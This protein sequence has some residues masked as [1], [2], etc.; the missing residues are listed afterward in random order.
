MMLTIQ[1]KQNTFNNLI[2]R[3]VGLEMD[4]NGTLVD[5]DSLTIFSFKGKAI[6]IMNIN[7]GDI[8]YDPYNNNK[9]MR[10]IFEFFTHK[11]KEETGVD[12]SAFYLTNTAMNTPGQGM[13][14]TDEGH[15]ESALYKLDC[16]K[17]AELILRL[18]GTPNAFLGDLDAE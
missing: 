16:L 1:Q 3:E 13:A 14:E 9:L 7:N 15:V 18:N 4:S 10:C 8:E 17:Y 11:I 5:Q 2:L 6:Q 12:V